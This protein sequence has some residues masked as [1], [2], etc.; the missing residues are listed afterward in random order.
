M[1]FFF[2]EYKFLNQT[3]RNKFYPNSSSKRLIVNSRIGFH[4]KVTLKTTKI[5]MHKNEI[6]ALSCNVFIYIRWETVFVGLI[7]KF[8]I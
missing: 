6:L 7:Q 3:Y 5:S 2:S 8:P 4:N 1:D